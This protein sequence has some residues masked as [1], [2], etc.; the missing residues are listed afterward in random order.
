MSWRLNRPKLEQLIERDRASLDESLVGL[1]VEKLLRLKA[2][3]AMRE[4]GG[5]PIDLS[6]ARTLNLKMRRGRDEAGYVPSAVDLEVYLSSFEQ[7]PE[8]ALRTLG[9]KTDPSSMRRRISLMLELD[10]SA[11]AAEL[12][13]KTEWHKDWT[14]VGVAALVLNDD[15]SAAVELVEWV[16]RQDD[17]ARDRTA[18]R[19][20]YETYKRFQEG[21]ALDKRHL[22]TALQVL[23]PALAAVQ[24]RGHV[25]NA[26]ESEVV[27]LAFHLHESLEDSEALTDLTPI[28]EKRRPVPLILARAA[29]T[30]W[31]EPI[32]DL[33]Q[34]LREEHPES[35]L[36]LFM[37]ASADAEL[38]GNREGAFEAALELRERAANSQHKE[39]L[40][41]L[42]YSLASDHDEDVLASVQQ[43]SRELGFS[44][45]IFEAAMDAHRL[46]RT[47]KSEEA[48]KRLDA[49]RDES[50]P[51]WLQIHSN[52]LL[53]I[54]E[55]DRAVDA[56]QKA[57]DIL[58]H[59]DL[60]RKA[61]ALAYEAGRFS[62][63][64]SNLKRY[65][66]R[67][68]GD[69]EARRGLAATFMNARWYEDAVTQVDRLIEMEPEEPDHY[70]TK[71]TCY[72]LMGDAEQ[73]L[74][75]TREL[76]RSRE[77]TL[78]AVLQRAQILRT[79]DR[80]K[81]AFDL[82]VEFRNDYWS[83]PD[84]LLMYLWLGYGAQE[85]AA[86]QE[87]MIRL[88]RL[89]DEGVVEEERLQRK[90]LEDV[91]EHIRVENERRKV[92]RDHLLR[93]RGPWLLVD[94]LLG[95]SPFWSWSIRTQPLPWL[96]EARDARADFTIYST[97]SFTRG[98]RDEEARLVRILCPSSGQGFLGDLSGLITLHRLGLLEDAV[99]YFGKLYL[100]SS[101]YSQALLERVRL[102]HHQ[103]SR[104][105]SVRA[106]KRA[107]EAERLYLGSGDEELALEVNEYSDDSRREGRLVLRVRDVLEV[108]YT[109]G[110]VSHERLEKALA[111]KLREPTRTV[112]GVEL[113]RGE[114]MVGDLETLRT[115]AQEDL[116]EVFLDYFQVWL[117]EN[118]YREMVY[119]IENLRLGE[120]LWKSHRE[121]WDMLRKHPAI[122][123]LP[124]SAPRIERE[125][126]GIEAH[127]AACR[128][129]QERGLPLFADDRVLQAVRFG[130]EHATPEDAFGTDALLVAL[131]RDGKISVEKLADAY[132]S[133]T[134]W[135]YRFLVLP[136]EVLVVYAA[137][138]KEHPP[139]RDLRRVAEY[140]HD[141]MCDPGLL[142]GW[143]PETD[144]QV[145]M[146]HKFFQAWM[147]TIVQFVIE[148][149]RDDRFTEEARRVLTN[150]C[151][152]A[153]F[154]SAPSVLGFRG[155]HLVETSKYYVI[156]RALTCTF[157]SEGA[158]R[159]NRA[160]VA[161]GEGLGLTDEEY[162]ELV[163]R[164]LYSHARIN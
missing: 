133:L 103:P 78:T 68:P 162:L 44:D 124:D 13:S 112:A 50:D 109:A 132:L 95:R 86:A 60:L 22:K 56:L 34:R 98:R 72:M 148:L 139:G 41:R 105:A 164:T 4:A 131:W 57:V 11:E 115:L 154:P 101:Y 92:L 30:G 52:Y 71:A 48:R 144:P 149:W 10:R 87:A 26:L 24:A 37:A 25:V 143:E 5:E 75:A 123:V 28:L 85:E 73:A 155:L 121:L 127:L 110:E 55:R 108:L 74:A 54:G 80:T 156:A 20:S 77:P 106:V 97:N 130:V 47:G 81:D 6:E 18:L 135:R 15:V 136:W 36:A 138:Y 160:L 29:L 116:L 146:A 90:S 129:A 59:P 157:E 39:D 31:I 67:R 16:S 42:L 150:W 9:E 145:S 66:L 147:E 114:S 122:V 70:Q 84:F 19:F 82:L 100:P 76:F 14:E 141:S 142:G 125:K 1:W 96:A 158:E 23:A 63:V 33:P 58:P 83:E 27:E 91:K 118:D 12:V 32:E 140:V 43:D 117:M 137:R 65:L 151:C 104:A 128:L 107:L 7:R 152:S 49:S 8:V 46:L 62:E 2:T 38:F 94:D 161:L 79:L 153:F 51:H 64:A 61:A 99:Q 21:A 17:A 163:L 45:D 134:Q 93:N 53:Q 120:Q 3:L 102:L 113:G 69:L 88:F 35:M 89:Q 40:G 126:E 119:K 111:K 159:A